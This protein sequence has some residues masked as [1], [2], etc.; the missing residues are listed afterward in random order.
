MA[1]GCSLGSGEPSR[2]RIDVDEIVTAVQFQD[3]V[4]IFC[5]SGKVYKMAHDPIYGYITF[6]LMAELFRP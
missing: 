6:V 5:R 1:N 4:F 3:C 2:R